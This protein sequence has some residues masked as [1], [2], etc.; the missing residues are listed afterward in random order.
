MTPM[1]RED[2]RVGVPNKKKYKLILNSDETRFGGNGNVIPA[3]IKAEAIP[4]DNRP[5]SISFSL[6]PY[7]A[8]VF[9][10]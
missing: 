7:G 1:A 5:Y 10:F 8:A 9:M 3:E 2:F 6:P 4:W